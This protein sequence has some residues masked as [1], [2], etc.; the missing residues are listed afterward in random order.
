MLPSHS[1]ESFDS[2]DFCET[3]MDGQVRPRYALAAPRLAAPDRR[4]SAGRRAQVLAEYV[5]LG[6]SGA[7][8]RSTTKV[9]ES[10][11]ASHEDCPVITVDGSLCGQGSGPACELFLKPRKL[12]KDPFR[13]GD[14]LLVL[15]DTFAVNEVRSGAAAPQAQRPRR[16]VRRNG[17]GPGGKRQRAPRPRPMPA[18]PPLPVWGGPAARPRAPAAAGSAPWAGRYHHSQTAG[19]G[20]GPRRIGR[21]LA[22]PRRGTDSHAPPRRRP[23]AR[24]PPRTPATTASPAR[25]CSRLRRSTSRCTRPSRTS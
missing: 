20:R 13:G 1:F 8:L 15:C 18:P 23:P 6:G 21:A 9:L 10:R 5:W 3:E 7:D 12:F 4:L 16:G 17:S 19:L 14:H 22:A 11:P 24:S 25:R 2:M